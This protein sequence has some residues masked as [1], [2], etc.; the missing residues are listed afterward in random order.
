MLLF[1]ATVLEQLDLALEH[2]SKADVHNARFSLMLTDNALEL[3]FHQIAKDKASYL[4]AYPSAREEY[5][6]LAALN[7]ASG[8]SFEAKVNFAKREAELSEESARTIN[9]LHE[10]RNQVYHIGLQHE[11]ILPNLAPFYFKVACECIGGYNRFE[12]PLEW[13]SSQKLPERVKRY[14]CSDGPMPGRSEDFENGCRALAKKCGHQPAET[15]AALADDMERV[16]DNQDN[17]IDIVAGGVCEEQQTTRD[18]AVIGCQAWS[19]AFSKG[20]AFAQQR[21]WKGS[22]AFQLIEW[23]GDNYPFRFKRDPI[24][25]WRTQIAKLRAQKNPHAALNQY[26][27]FMTE[28]ADLRE[29]VKE[30]AASLDAQ[31]TF[32]VDR[33]LGR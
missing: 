25:S 6:H 13:S 20:K 21:G 5:P 26:H 18:N 17:G 29:A 24:A 22:N 11:E 4:K 27:S 8:R 3:F 1:L 32:E 30:A 28:T 16:V 7:K 12:S 9:I 14:F 15:I 10:I 19:L 33:A 23:L 2:V 31:I